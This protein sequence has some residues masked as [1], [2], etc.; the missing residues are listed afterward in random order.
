VTT[1]LQ[2]IK[3]YYYYFNF[4]RGVSIKFDELFQKTN[5]TEDTNKLTSLAFKIIAILHT[6]LLATFIMLLE[7]VNKGLFRNRSRVLA[8]PPHG[9]NAR[10]RDSGSAIDS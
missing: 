6:T 5:K 2:L 10:T 4:I 7:T 9:S 3:Y 8:L 1:Q